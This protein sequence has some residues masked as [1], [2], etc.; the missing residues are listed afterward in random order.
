MSNFR[1]KRI[2][3]LR[4]EQ[5]KRDMEKSLKALNMPIEIEYCIEEKGA[6]TYEKTSQTSG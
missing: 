6:K 2:V 3:K 5:L 4:G 1:Y